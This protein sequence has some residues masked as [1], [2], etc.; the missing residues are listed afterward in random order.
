[1]TFR[2]ARV[3]HLT[4]MVLGSA[5]CSIVE[6]GV[7][8]SASSGG[9]EDAGAEAGDAGGGEASSVDA[10]VCTPPEAGLPCDPGVI[11]CP[12]EK[13]MT[14]QVAAGL[15]CCQQAFM[16]SCVLPD[17]SASSCDN[18]TRACDETADCPAGDQCWGMVNTGGDRFDTVCSK[19][20]PPGGQFQLC[21]SNSDCASSKCTVQHCSQIALTGQI[22]TCGPIGVPGCM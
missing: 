15:V 8:G 1:M 4:L 7:I 12:G 9:K 2:P 22:E 11:D 21:K 10:W 19:G 14:C 5:A 6:A 18:G 13:G 16:Y 20:Q 3:A 17:A